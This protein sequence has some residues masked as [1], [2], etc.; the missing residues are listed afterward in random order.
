M[1]N[2]KKMSE[3]ETFN[4]EMSEGQNNIQSTYSEYKIVCNQKDQKLIFQK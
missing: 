4:A 1:R 2:K 3:S